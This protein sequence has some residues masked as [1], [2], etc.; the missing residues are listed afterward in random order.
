VT[1]AGRERIP[2]GRDGESSVVWLGT[3]VLESTEELLVSPSGRFLLFATPAAP[4]A[5]DS[6]RR[7]L[8][9]RL[10]LDR[11]VDDRES[12]KTLDAAGAIAAEA[13]AAG[14]R[15]DDALVAVG[16]GVVTD[17]V[18]FAAAILLRGVAWNAVPT[19]TAGMADAAI[20]GKTGVNHPL[21]KNLLGAFH[22]PAAVLA[23][24]SVL[25]TLPD[26][27]HRAGLVEALKAVWIGNADLAARAEREIPALRRRDAEALRELLGGA[28]RVKA[29]IV[30]DDPRDASRRQLLN[31]GHTLGH[32]LEAA[33]GFAALRHGEAVAWGIA[34]AVEIS[35]RRA[36]L[37]AD[38]AGR[39]LAALSAIGPFPPPERDPG[40]LR[41]F[42]AMDKKATA[43]GT[44]AILL[45]AIGSPRID[46][47]V[48]AEEWLDAAAIMSLS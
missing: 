45:A 18:G 16:G 13:L 2:V 32:A 37:S 6:V 40:R 44:A 3:G 14:V 11:T 25:A 12:A 30:A 38:E 35:R 22:P 23:D 41:P 4:A 43:R 17:V 1:P 5:A 7:A 28:I 47:A 42:L 31:F 36:G 15:R 19:T 8:G 39:I 34:A 46:P 10:L 27:D 9:K 26:R 21:G 33:G 29:A 48:T 24:P 20:G